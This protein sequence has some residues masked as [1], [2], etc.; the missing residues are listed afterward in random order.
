[1]FTKKLPRLTEIIDKESERLILWIPVIVGLA[2][3]FSISYFDTINAGEIIFCAIVFLGAL[4]GYLY[5]R[6]SYRSFIFSA[7]AI[8]LFGF[9]SSFF[10]QKFSNNYTKI[11]GKIFVDV[12]AS[13]SD[14]NKFTNKVNGREG[15]NLLLSQ[16]IFYQSEF[17]GN[18]KNKREKIIDEEYILKNLMNVSR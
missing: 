17:R 10:Y 12:R 8:F 11:T 3:Y 13:V 9:L 14:I 6:Y 2:A 7:C 4:F 16:P 5:N 15:F 18:K 1:M